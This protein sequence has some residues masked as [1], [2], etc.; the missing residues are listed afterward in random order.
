MHTYN[1]ETETQR[2]AVLRPRLHGDIEAEL[3]LKAR[4]SSTQPGP[5]MVYQGCVSH[6]PSSGPCRVV[7]P[8]P[9]PFHFPGECGELSCH[10]TL[11]CWVS[12][13]PRH[14]SWVLQVSWE[15][16][17]SGGLSSQCD[18]PAAQP[19]SEVLVVMEVKVSQIPDKMLGYPSPW[20]RCWV[21]FTQ[22]WA[23]T[24]TPA[25]SWVFKTRPQCR[26]QWALRE[27]AS[28]WLQWPSALSP[29]TPAS[30][31]GGL[32]SASQHVSYAPVLCRSQRAWAFKMQS[33]KEAF[34][35]LLSAKEGKTTND[36]TWSWG[37]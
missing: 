20:L 30:L 8:L 9:R 4:P 3:W 26:S 28:L 35:S 17:G 11:T 23:L 21:T 10:P 32:S 33:Q 22:V 5:F 1:V 7:S 2:N 12:R 25:G 31:G 16:A 15:S 37:D 6:C 29:P 27:T 34:F 13:M 19:L 18:N 24:G 36:G 14:F